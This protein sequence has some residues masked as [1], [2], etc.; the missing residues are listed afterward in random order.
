MPA[1]AWRETNFGRA[2]P[3]SP[4]ENQ[5]TIEGRVNIQA[6]QVA[7]KFSSNES[8]LACMKINLLGA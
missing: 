4:I 5:L 8:E 1:A 6:V 7:Q 3:F 2:C